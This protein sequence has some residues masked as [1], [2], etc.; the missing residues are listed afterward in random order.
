MKKHLMLAMG[1]LS[2]VTAIANTTPDTTPAKETRP[3]LAI[4]LL[5]LNGKVAKPI[6]STTYSVSQKNLHLCWEAVNVPFTAKNQVTEIF[7]APAPAKFTEQGVTVVS[8]NDGKTHTISRQLASHN[9]EFIR[10][11]W[12]FD[13]TDPKGEYTLQVRINNIEFPAMPFNIVK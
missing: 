2:S 5:D 3:M 11:C 8:S 7:N 13:K 4:Y 1:L 12:K 10:K 6:R 9:N